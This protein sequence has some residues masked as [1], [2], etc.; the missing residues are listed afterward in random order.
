MQGLPVLCLDFNAW[1][2]NLIG[3]VFGLTWQAMPDIVINR[4]NRPDP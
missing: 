4:F 1:G 3:R 2:D